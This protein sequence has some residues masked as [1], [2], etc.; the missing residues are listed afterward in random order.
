MNPF[1][2]HWLRLSLWL[3]VASPIVALVVVLI[4]GAPLAVVLIVTFWV[5][6]VVCVIL[7]AIA[8]TGMVARLAHR[9]WRAFR[10]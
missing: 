9:G 3:L 4:E 5:W 7:A 6:V 2:S 10:R 1:A 8:L